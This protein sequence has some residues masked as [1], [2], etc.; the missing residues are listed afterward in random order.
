MAYNT[1]YAIALLLA[2]RTHLLTTLTCYLYMDL[3]FNLSTLNDILPL[4]YRE[5]TPLHYTPLMLPFPPLFLFIC[6][7]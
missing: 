5:T 3:S 1:T 7:L 2:Y 4:L 6:Y